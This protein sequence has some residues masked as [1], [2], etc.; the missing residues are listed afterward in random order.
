MA[1]E[2]LSEAI[3]KT[4]NGSGNTN[5][6]PEMSGFT[7]SSE[8]CSNLTEKAPRPPNRKK[9]D[10]ELADLTVKIKELEDAK[11]KSSEQLRLAR[12]QVNC[13]RDRRDQISGQKYDVDE[14][15]N[16]INKSV[17][18]KK[19]VLQRLKAAFVVISED[20]LDDQ[21]STYLLC[22]NNNIV[23][24]LYFFKYIICKETYALI[25]YPPKSNSKS[26]LNLK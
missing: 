14:K 23:Q 24:L 21:V 7:G 12:E 10:E 6:F 26:I 25:F 5:I 1:T 2:S 8:T 16:V 4:I 3:Y 13:F 19:D 17:E 15:L 9:N 18:V 22:T 20:K 11:Q